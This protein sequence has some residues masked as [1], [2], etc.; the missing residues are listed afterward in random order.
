MFCYLN[1]LQVQR[2][3]DYL[4][5]DF[6]IIYQVIQQ[7]LTCFLQFTLLKVHLNSFLVI[8]PVVYLLQFCKQRHLFPYLIESL[9][10]QSNVRQSVDDSLQL[11]NQFGCLTFLR[12]PF[13]LFALFC[14]DHFVTFAKQDRLVS[15]HTPVYLILSSFVNSLDQF[16][17]FTASFVRLNHRVDVACLFQTEVETCLCPFKRGLLG[18]LGHSYRNTSHQSVVSDFLLDMIFILVDSEFFQKS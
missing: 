5:L 10:S 1:R 6:I 9:Q 14:L 16:Y 3:F 11:L 18:D 15:H 17:H 2:L 7:V 8:L 4:N 12:T 13:L